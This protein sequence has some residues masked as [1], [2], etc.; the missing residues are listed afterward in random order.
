MKIFSLVVTAMI[1]AALNSQFVAAV[2]IRKATPI[3]IIPEDPKTCG[4]TVPYLCDA[5]SWV[6]CYNAICKNEPTVDPNKYDG[7]PF[8]ECQCWQPTKNP[9]NKYTGEQRN[10]S[11]LPIGRSGTNCV[12]DLPELAEG[13]EKMC[14]FMQA[15][16]LISTSSPYGVPREYPSVQFDAESA[17]CLAGTPFV[18]CWGA[19]CRFTPDTP[20]GITCD[21][22]YQTSAVNIP[23]QIS[24]AGKAECIGNFGYPS[25]PCERTHASMP[26]GLS[27]NSLSGGFCYRE[28]GLKTPCVDCCSS[29]DPSPTP[30]KSKSKSKKNRGRRGNKM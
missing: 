23:Q 2:D 1:S 28:K 4:L 9:D 8:N 7:K 6:F 21:C 12:L 27:P 18:L 13:G 16:G 11:I 29:D 26:A 24:L 14:K 30:P 15:G 22:S 20:T 5:E 25:N 3:P 19:P 17:L 10:T